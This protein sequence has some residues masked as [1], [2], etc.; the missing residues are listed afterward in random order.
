MTLRAK[1]LVFALIISIF[2]GW[3]MLGL[4]KRAVEN[5]L[6]EEVAKRGILKTQDLPA[7]TAAGFR[8]R[9]E[10]V[11][12]TM[13][14][15]GR[16]AT[17]SVYAMA[18]DP[19]GTVVAHT[20][21]VEKGRVLSDR[22]TQAALQAGQPVYQKRQSAEG[23]V[24][25]L[26]LPVWSV[27]QAATGEEFLLF[28]GEELKESTRLGTLR[29][30]IPIR[31]MEE[32]VGRISVQMA[33][34]LGAAG[35]AAVALSL[36]FLQRI[37][38][39][40][41]ILSKGTDRIGRG[42]YGITVTVATKDE[43]GAL[44]HNFNRMSAELASAYGNLEKEVKH[45]TQ[46]L[47]SFVY[48]VSHDLKSPIVSMQGMASI[49]LEDFGAKVDERGRYY[50]ERIIANANFM[51][52]L[53][54]D[55]LTL[56]RVGR[57]KD[58]PEL[59]DVHRVIFDLLEIHKERFASNRVEVVVDPALPHFM[60]ERG[61]LNQ[62]FQNLIINAVKFMDQQPK[63]R[64]EVGGVETEKTVEFHVK[65]NGIGID[66]EY[67]HKIFGVFQRLKDV[68]VEGTGIGLSIVKK[69]MD[70]AGGSVRLE[71]E[72]G[73]GA[74]FYIRFPRP[75]N[76]PWSAAEGFSRRVGGPR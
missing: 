30:G 2:T 40:I 33:T 55:L 15:E 7:A 24:L 29:F 61:H 47:E 19:E 56:S 71:S 1:I 35:G 65:D 72:K 52:Q 5:I 22:I 50:L 73:K 45:R 37:L 38:G 25:D 18:L 44:A 49:F 62:V 75:S 4:S 54:N 31:D 46:E 53:I 59:V 39:R 63:P 74:A 36:L 69:I 67:H 68:E 12:L 66:P 9:D 51:E 21:V 57:K 17:G 70:L 14:Q 48:T 3:L 64:V 6:S 27:K 60:Y 28:G 10:Q 58:N 8:S 11:L 76:S 34:I 43:L 26:S 42:E 41:R 23:P 32:T 13:L 16:V 20:N